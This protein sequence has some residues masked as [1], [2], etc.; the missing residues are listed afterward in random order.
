LLGLDAATKTEL[1]GSL[2]MTPEA[3]R[4]REAE[5]ISRLME[6]SELEKAVSVSTEIGRLQAELDKIH[7]PARLRYLAARD[8]GR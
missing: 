6:T 2:D 8:A 4:R 1:S 7:E 3:E 5:Q